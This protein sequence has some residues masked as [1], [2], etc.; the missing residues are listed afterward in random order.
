MTIPTP[1]DFA[2]IEQAIDAA[3]DAAKA[4]KLDCCANL[5]DLHC[6]DVSWCLHNVEGKLEFYWLG[7]VSEAAQDD[8]KLILFIREHLT[9]AGIKDRAA[10]ETFW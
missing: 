10:I 5:A 4:C 8:T 2:A 1:A 7:S 3:C 6:V 9:D